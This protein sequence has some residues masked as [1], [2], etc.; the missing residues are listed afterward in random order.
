[1]RLGGDRVVG[2]LGLVVGVVVRVVRVVVEPGVVVVGRR[3]QVLRF[4]VRKRVV[5]F[6]VAVVV[7]GAPN[8]GEISGGRLAAPVAKAVMEAV[9]AP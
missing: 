7:E 9:L 4:L 5:V 2:G 3:V 1:M 6:A 8:D